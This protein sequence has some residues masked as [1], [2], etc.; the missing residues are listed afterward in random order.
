MSLLIKKLAAKN[1]SLENGP[2]NLQDAYEALAARL[3][4]DATFIATGGDDSAALQAFIDAN[5]GR[6]I[7][8]RGACTFAGV[9]LIGA[10]YNG[11]RLTIQNHKLKVRGE[12]PAT[13][14]GAWVGLLLKDVD[15][16][17]LDYFGDGQRSLQPQIEQ[18]FLVG[19]AGG[20]NYRFGKVICTE[21]RGDGL[22]VG[23]SEWTS[24]STPPT[25]IIIDSFIAYNSA[26]D[27]RNGMSIISAK[28]M[29]VGAFTS[30]GV[31]GVVN[32][33]RMP[34]GL[35][36]ESDVAHHTIEDVSFG[37]VF[38]R[39]AGTVCVGIIGKDAGSENYSAKRIS[40]GHIDS[41][42]TYASS[43]N[44]AA[45]LVVLWAEDVTVDGGVVS[46]EN[47]SNGTGIIVDYVTGAEIELKI[48]KAKYGAQIGATGWVRKSKI[49]L[50]VESY[51]GSG[52]VV[53]GATDSRIS[54]SVTG[55]VSST[56]TFAVQT[57]SGG[58]ALTQSKVIYSV[59]CPYDGLN[60]RGYRNEPGDVVTF[61][62]CQIVNCDVSGY[63]SSVLGMDGVAAGMKWRD[64]AGYDEIT[65]IPSSGEW[66][67][68]HFVRSN[69]AGKD[70]NNMFV[71]GWRR[72]TTGTNHAEGVDWMPARASTVSPAL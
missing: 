8:V 65:A 10:T 25:N 63:A 26:D 19:I 60:L 57:K 23:Q 28:T 6:H 64:V 39:S 47:A 37:S 67:V 54:G 21:V 5:K 42:C 15:G 13:F 58:R 56:L 20:S 14:G 30:I 9:T 71:M 38:V 24:S 53:S 2:E 27:G 44:G 72:L 16:C 70:A 52:F 33:A 59:H 62:N 45:A 36:M 7:V 43:T 68:G 18:T 11:T 66:P 12:L 69:N 49:H 40:I 17:Q 1:V 61:S 31:G 29:H 51:N 34:G 48:P 35:D 4:G 3:Y 55:A 32:G 50:D 41:R 46:Q 22:Y